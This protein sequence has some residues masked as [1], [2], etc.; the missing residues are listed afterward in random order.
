MIRHWMLGATIGAVLFGGREWSRSG[1][2][3]V[4]ILPKAPPEQLAQS[5]G[6][7]AAAPEAMLDAERIVATPVTLAPRYAL[8]A[9]A[10]PVPEIDP[11]NSGYPIERSACLTIALG[12]NAAAEC[13]NLRV[14]QALPG[15]RVFNTTV[16][17]T[18]IYNSEF[19][20]PY[21]VVPVF[22]KQLSTTTQPQTV[23]VKVSMG[24][25]GQALVLKATHTWAGTDWPAGQTTTRRVTVSWDGL[26]DTTGY[27]YYEAE[28]TNIYPGNVRVTNATKPSGK[29]FLINR[30]Q[31][32][33]GAGWWLAGLER[34]INLGT[35]EKV[36]I[37]GD[38]SARFFL[39][40]G[41][42]PYTTISYAPLYDRKDSLAYDAGT[43]T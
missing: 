16:A 41:P 8:F 19:A 22:I 24:V 3:E 28:V 6:S 20:H 37:G 12:A 17:P 10:A 14:T 34:L 7:R 21:P 9:Q 30:S 23:E 27:Y 33:F 35:N 4:T 13:G 2:R 1:A 43:A 11:R 31:S 32:P 15:V 38:G 5:L 29:M 18:L 26:A 36:W 39:N 42:P 25:Y 40:W